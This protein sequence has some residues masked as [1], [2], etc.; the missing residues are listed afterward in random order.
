MS[1]KFRNFFCLSVLSLL[2]CG[3]LSAQ[4]SV[5]DQV[6]ER[7]I[8]AD[9]ES[10][11]LLQSSTNVIQQGQDN[12]IS[13]QQV[14]RQFI[15]VQQTGFENELDL[16]VAG[17]DNVTLLNQTGFNNTMNLTYTGEDNDIRFSQEGVN[18]QADVDLGTIDGQY[19]NVEQRNDNNVIE[20]DSQID[21]S[22]SVPMSIIQSGES[23]LRISGDGGF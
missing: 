8:G 13:I 14:D 10:L 12:Q 17:Q 9:A 19:L 6:E 15:Q 22:I 16:S 2:L 18:N 21:G 1:N 11:G 20:H 5:A 3:G 23:R 4:V 7:L